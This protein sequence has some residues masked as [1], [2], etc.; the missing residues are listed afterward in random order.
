V[1]SVVHAIRRQPV[2]LLPSRFAALAVLLVDE[3]S[4]DEKL[5]NQAF[6]KCGP[7]Q[8]AFQRVGQGGQVADEESD[9]ADGVQLDWLILLL[10]IFVGLVFDPVRFRIFFI[11]GA[12]AGGLKGAA[13][14][15]GI[16]G[17]ETI[18]QTS[19]TLKERGP[20]RVDE[21]LR[22]FSVG[23]VDRDG[24]DA[25]APTTAEELVARFSRGKR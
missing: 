14:G 22:L 19:L 4:I 20:R 16:G 18:Y 23:D 15:A 3:F 6:I 25:P 11:V 8:V 2:R 1:I 24:E 13:I 7:D 10:G 12:I 17:L 9:L 5:F 21:R